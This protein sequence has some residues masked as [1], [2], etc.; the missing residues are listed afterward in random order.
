MDSGDP[1]GW[2]IPSAVDFV[3]RT[4]VKRW[5]L[6]WFFVKVYTKISVINSDYTIR[7]N[8]LQREGTTDQKKKRERE[9]SILV[10]SSASFAIDGNFVSKRR[11]KCTRN[12]NKIH[13][14]CYCRM[15][16]EFLEKYSGINGEN[17][18]KGPQSNYQWAF[19]N[20]FPR[21]L[22]E[23]RRDKFRLRGRGEA[24]LPPC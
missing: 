1:S 9:N 15:E 24:T 4:R 19:A 20:L 16:Q 22:P 3:L 17:C 12:S 8:H 18:T 23:D 13:P 6:E 7:D 10:T 2:S 14:K 5:F 21:D 11:K